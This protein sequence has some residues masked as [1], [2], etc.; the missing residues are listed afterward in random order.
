MGGGSGKRAKNTLE[1]ADHVGHFS[2]RGRI[3]NVPYKFP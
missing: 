2:F 3:E 1:V